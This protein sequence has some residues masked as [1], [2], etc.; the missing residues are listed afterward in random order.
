[1]L[2]KA[3]VTAAALAALIPAALAQAQFGTDKEAKA[4]LDK[5]VSAVKADKAK[6]LDQFQKG[7]AGYK[8]RDLYVFCAA[9]ADGTVTAHPTL[10]GKKLQEVVDKTGKKL[11]EEMM[12]TAAEGKVTEVSYMWPRP[13]ADTTPV[14]KVTYVTKVADQVCGVGYYK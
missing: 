3:I 8:D 7:E 12:K 9:A 11:G 2:R 4:M 13:G 1:M 14:Q 10:K 6:A 5:A